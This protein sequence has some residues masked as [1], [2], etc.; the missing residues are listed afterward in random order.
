LEGVMRSFNSIHVPYFQHFSA[1][2]AFASAR[3]K[4]SEHSI[5]ITLTLAILF[6]LLIALTFWAVVAR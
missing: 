1:R 2:S 3:D 4:F 6:G 5:E